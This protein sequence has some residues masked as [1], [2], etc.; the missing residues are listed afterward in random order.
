MAK[1]SEE[2]TVR[3]AQQSDFDWLCEQDSQHVDR[4]WIERCIKDSEYIIAEIKNTPGDLKG[5]I[6]FSL[7]WGKIPYMNMI[8]VVEG[9]QLQGVGSA[10]MRFWENQMRERGYTTLMTSY[11]R[12]EMAAQTWH[13]RNGY[14]EA[15]KLDLGL[16]QTVPEVFFIKEL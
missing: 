13:W 6:R 5:Y 14:R 12:D 16:A 2:I 4:G 1:L 10:L 11:E 3:Y 7:F 9:N 8:R 15:G